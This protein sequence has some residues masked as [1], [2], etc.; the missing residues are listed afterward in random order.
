M[1]Q[2][3]TITTTTGLQ[4]AALDFGG[5]GD[6]VLLL[7]G[8]GRSA[9]DWLSMAPHLTPHGRV[10][11]MDLRGH[12]Q[13]SCGPWT[14]DHALAD[15][16][17]VIGRY[18]ARR[19]ILIGHSLGGVLATVFALK[20]N[21]VRA[22]INLDGFAL[23]ADEYVGI[24][25]AEAIEFRERADLKW[26]WSSPVLTR[27]KVHAAVL[28]TAR[29][30]GLEADVA[31]AVVFRRLAA[32]NQDTYGYRNDTITRDGVR[33]LYRSFLLDRSFFELVKGSTCPSLFFR[34]KTG[35]PPAKMPD[36]QRALDNAYIRGLDSRIAV[37]EESERATVLPRE[38]SH[39]ML[40]EEPAALALEINAFLS[41]L[42]AY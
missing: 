17:E 42:R 16:D 14:L 20:L 18:E 26:D 40:L 28:E 25:A 12:G 2:A 29:H 23:H 1:P 35:T 36:W 39:M 30:Y 15:I 37:L 33:D 11:A 24:S 8:A 9:A 19:P 41:A 4:L 3:K 10:V 34:S 13:S 38:T 6:L 22:L 32:L 21:A 5:E 31:T 7:H 27:K